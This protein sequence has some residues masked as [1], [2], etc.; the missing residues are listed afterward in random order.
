[1]KLKNVK[2][3]VE[4]VKQIILKINVKIYKPK[5]KRNNLKLKCMSRN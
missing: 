5:P 2:T 1:M 4:P 3:G